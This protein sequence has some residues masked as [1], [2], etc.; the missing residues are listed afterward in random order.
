MKLILFV[1]L[2]GFWASNT[3]C[4]LV[5]QAPDLPSYFCGSTVRDFNQVKGGD[6]K[7][8]KQWKPLHQNK[9]WLFPLTNLTPSPTKQ[10]A[11]QILI[12]VAVCMKV[13]H[14]FPQMFAKHLTASSTPLPLQQLTHLR[15]SSTTEL[16]RSLCW[17]ND[18]Y[19]LDQGL[20]VM[21]LNMC[22]YLDIR[23]IHHITKSTF[24]LY[25]LIFEQWK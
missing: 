12:P 14:R 7:V 21:S 24:Q 19:D 17:R 2:S 10:M 20:G 25:L 9:C 13:I 6:A 8:D 23:S 4:W 22:R 18:D 16:T 15:I 11:F 3:C 1:P 5:W